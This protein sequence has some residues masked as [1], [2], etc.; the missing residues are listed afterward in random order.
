MTSTETLTNL[1]N[2]PHL[3][4]TA[5]LPE[6]VAKCANAGLPADVIEWAATVVSVQTIQRK[7]PRVGFG[8]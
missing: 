7:R 4:P 6:F 5:E 2:N 3:I 8:F 1:I